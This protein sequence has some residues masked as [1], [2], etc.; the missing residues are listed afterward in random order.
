MQLDVVNVLGKKVSEIELNDLVFKIKP[1]NQ[2]MYDLYLY[3]SAK[4]RQGTH[5]TKNRSDVSGGGK[6]PWR[7]KGTGRARQGSIRSPQWKGGGVVFGPQKNKNYELKINKKVRKLAFR[8]GF[9]ELIDN[10]E[11]ILLDNINFN[12][13]STKDFTVLLKNLQIEKQKTLLILEKIEPNFKTFLSARNIQQ[14]NIVFIDD[15]LLTDIL[16]VKKVITTE[17]AIKILE[18]RWA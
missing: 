8:S 12:K 18:G 2:A 15:L 17:S 9:S 10:N 11:L 13:P 6:K 5:S 14:V 1:N 4:S 16:K 7:Q 3:E